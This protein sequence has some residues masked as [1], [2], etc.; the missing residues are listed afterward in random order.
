MNTSRKGYSWCPATITS[1]MLIYTHFLILVKSAGTYYKDLVHGSWFDLDVVEDGRIQAYIKGG[2][3]FGE[4]DDD[5]YLQVFRN[6][7]EINSHTGTL[8]I[9][10]GVA[11]DDFNV[12]AHIM[13][14]TIESE[15]VRTGPPRESTGNRPE[16]FVDNMILWYDE[17]KRAFVMIYQEGCYSCWSSEYEDWL[18]E[19]DLDALNQTLW[20]IV[21]FDD[22]ATWTVREQ[23]LSDVVNPH[24]QFQLIPGVDV[25]E[26]GYPTEILIPIHHL[27]EEDAKQNYQSL[28]RCNRAINPSDGSWSVVNM[29]STSDLEVLGGYIQA[30]IVRPWGGKK[31]V[32]FLRDRNGWWMGRS[33]STDDGR[34]W[35]D[36]ESTPL[37]NA[38]LMNQAIWL[39]SG[40][41]MLVYN[42]QQSF[43]SVPDA[44]DRVDNTHMLVVAL[45]E[46]EGLSWAYSRTL[47][48][49]YDAIHEYPVGVKD[50]TCDNVFFTYSM[51]TNEKAVSCAAIQDEVAYEACLTKDIHM[52][53]IKFT[54]LH[55]SWVLDDHNWGYDYEGC[56]F[57]ISEELKMKM[58]IAVKVE[59]FNSWMF[60][61]SVATS[62]SHAIFIVLL[63]L[64]FLSFLCTCG[65]FL[66]FYRKNNLSVQ[67]RQVSLSRR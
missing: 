48:Y 40:K 46:D 62:P 45:S 58:P 60:S 10:F 35:V 2:Q 54:I 31:L 6:F 63:V 18:D 32:A 30:S 3:Y 61:T 44:G 39:N 21:S 50:T 33:E 27:D 9:A 26:N 14:L 34:S 29:S 67:V 13:T 53:F 43:T 64:V 38:D 41:V 36:I 24:V 52:Y 55:E 11:Y 28:Y 57:Q 16:W 56:T 19:H 5:P 1:C 66:Y 4:K 17:V 42:P 37:P 15:A 25:D 49:A 12:D 51:E 59:A 22:G 47:E 20:K 7:I 65:F 23:L 8:L